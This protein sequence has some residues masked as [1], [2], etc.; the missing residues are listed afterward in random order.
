MNN[1][2]RLLQ[3]NKDLLLSSLLRALGSAGEVFR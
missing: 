1:L 3:R 2:D